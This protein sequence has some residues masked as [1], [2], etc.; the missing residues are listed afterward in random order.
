MD[1]EKQPPVKGLPD[2]PQPSFPLAPKRKQRIRTLLRLST[3]F[4]VLFVVI[5]TSLYSEAGSGSYSS[6][7]PKLPHH[8]HPLSLKERENLF[9]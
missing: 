5:R 6:S 2:D 3:T 4:L 8:H 9:L 1:V 7:W